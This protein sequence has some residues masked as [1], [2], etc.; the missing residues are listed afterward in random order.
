MINE[1]LEDGAVEADSL[2][3]VKV[4]YL[5]THTNSTSELSDVVLP[6]LTSFE[7]SGSFINRGFFAQS[8]EQ[9]VPGPAGLRD[10]GLIVQ[11][12]GQRNHD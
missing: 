5:G 11:R 6:A 10:R 8:F 4:I 7:K 3:G 1:D 12:T 9:S 2:K